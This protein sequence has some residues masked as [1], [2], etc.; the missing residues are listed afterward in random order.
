MINKVIS[1]SRFIGFEDKNL[2]S[3]ILLSTLQIICGKGRMSLK[4]QEKY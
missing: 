4:M 3:L 2:T 1:N